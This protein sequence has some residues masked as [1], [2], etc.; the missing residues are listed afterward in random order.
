MTFDETSVRRNSSGQ[1]TERQGTAPELSLGSEGTRVVGNTVMLYAGNGAYVAEQK[2]ASPEVRKYNRQVAEARRRADAITALYDEDMDV[3]ESLSAG[4]DQATIDRYQETA[5]QYRDIV[6]FEREWVEEHNG[7]L[8]SFLPNEKK[9]R[10]FMHAIRERFGITPTRYAQLLNRVPDVVRLRDQL[11]EDGADE[12]SAT[13]E[14]RERLSG[15]R[16]PRPRF[17][18]KRQQDED[19]DLWEAQYEVDRERGNW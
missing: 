10:Q 1:F 12:A 19:F 6:A 5:Q 14:S 13:K 9:A 4:D 2:D 8:G 3:F 11:I 7:E 16:T 18:T 17:L 15:G